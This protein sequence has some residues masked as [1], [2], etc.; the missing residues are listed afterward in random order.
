[1]PFLYFSICLT[2]SG[3]TRP[4]LSEDPST[5]GCGLGLTGRHFPSRHPSQSASRQKPLVGPGRRLL[6]TSQ[7][8]AFLAGSTQGPVKGI[9]ASSRADK[10]GRRMTPAY[11]A[12]CPYRATSA[13]C[14]LDSL[15]APSGYPTPL[16]SPVAATD[17][18]VTIRRPS[19]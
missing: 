18:A 3:R 16:N 14:C 17:P 13:G 5:N 11:S 2:I 9:S 7:V 19:A 12:E 6:S 8:L 10:N 1:M 15:P 4:K